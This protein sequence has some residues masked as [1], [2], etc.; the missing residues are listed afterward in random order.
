L[1]NEKIIE[2]HKMKA[3]DNSTLPM[4]RKKSILGVGSK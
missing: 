2:K 4:S 1:K 3:I